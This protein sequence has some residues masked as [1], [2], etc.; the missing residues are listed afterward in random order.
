MQPKFQYMCA[1]CGYDKYQQPIHRCEHKEKHFA[2]VFD[3]GATKK[4]YRDVTR[5]LIKK[6][7]L[8]GL[9]TIIC[10][11][12]SCRTTVPSV[13]S[14]QKDSVAVSENIFYEDTTV[15]TEPDSASVTIPSDWFMPYD[16]ARTITPAPVK[17]ISK[18][19]SVTVKNDRGKITAT[20][21]CDSVELKLRLAQKE[22]TKYHLK[23]ESETKIVQQMYVPGIVKVL[24]WTGGISFLMGLIFLI[25]KIRS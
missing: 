15:Y 10:F 19:A 22:I 2:R 1:L 18:T 23:Q 3:Q 14:V 24:A 13:L 25:I 20:A 4:R 21:N 11:M 9:V 12:V 7:K 16:S 6:M 17:S 5:A 8:I